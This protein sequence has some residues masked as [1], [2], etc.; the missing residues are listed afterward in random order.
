MGERTHP[1]IVSSLGRGAAES[2]PTAPHATPRSRKK[3]SRKSGPERFWDRR[4]LRVAFVAMLAISIGVH[5]LASPWN[6]V[7]PAFEVRDVEGDTVIPIDLLDPDPPEPPPVEQQTGE[8]HDDTD[9]AGAT[10]GDASVARTGTADAGVEASTAIVADAAPAV[11]D[12]GDA[13]DASD[14]T[15]RS[16]VQ[17]VGD[18]GNLQAGEALVVLLI[19]AAEIKKHPIGSQMG[20]LL[21]SIPQWDDFI[22]GTGIDPINQT[23]WVLISGPGLVDT[24][25]DVIIIHYSAPDALVDRAIDIVSKKYDRGGPYDAGVPGVKAALAHADRAPRVFLRPQPHLLAVVPVH[26]ANTAAKI[27]VKSRVSPKVRPGEAVRLTVKRPYQPFPQIPN[28][29]SELRLWVLPRADGSAE[30]F[31]EGDCAT[32]AD[33]TDAAAQIAKIFTGFKSSTALRMFKPQLYALVNGVEVK[34][35]GKL[36]TLHLDASQEQLEELLGIVEGMVR[37]AKGT[38]PPAP[39]PSTTGTPSASPSSSAKKP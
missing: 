8:K 24:T 37:S 19:N 13:S 28:T 10:A 5:W 36:V 31:A 18:V 26:Y 11:V 14:A 33:A 17:M 3:G 7:P 22:S 23:D 21:S 16:P 35:S 9:Q 27:L 2:A 25:N 15:P 4:H 20:P 32:D 39:A 30:V 12:A 38:K 6:I 1:T 29:V 34:P